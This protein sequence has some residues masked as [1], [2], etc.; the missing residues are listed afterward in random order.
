MANV[1]DRAVK[2]PALVDQHERRFLL[3]KVVIVD[4]AA[5]IG[6][7]AVEEDIR[8]RPVTLRTRRRGGFNKCVLDGA[9]RPLALDQKLAQTHAHPVRRVAR[10][11]GSCLGGAC[12][13]RVQGSGRAY[14][15]PA[16]VREHKGMVPAAPASSVP[17]SGLRCTL[18]LEWLPGASSWRAGAAPANAAATSG[19]RPAK[20][21]R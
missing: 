16:V 8:H 13:G 3:L 18:R 11:L 15:P 14:S 17:G 7:A 6:T 2:S 5:A 21:C 19:S 10:H 1:G 12:L 20:P 4:P 9:D